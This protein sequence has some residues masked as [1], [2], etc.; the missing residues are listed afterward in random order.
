MK[1]KEKEHL[2]ADP[3]VHFMQQALAFFKGHRRPLLI[4]AGLAMSPAS[5]SASSAAVTR[6]CSAGLSRP[7]QAQVAVSSTVGGASH[8]NAPCQP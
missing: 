3:F 1:K 5:S 6:G 2:K 4:G 7:Y 8:S